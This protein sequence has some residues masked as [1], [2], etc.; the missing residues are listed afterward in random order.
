MCVINLTCCLRQLPRLTRLQ[1]PIDRV[2]HIEIR[3][4]KGDSNRTL[5]FV[6]AATSKLAAINQ[7]VNRLAPVTRK[8]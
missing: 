4:V 3:Q 6:V 1:Q 8:Q 5:L 7:C 2:H